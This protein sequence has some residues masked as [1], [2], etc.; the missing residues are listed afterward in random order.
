[1]EKGGGLG[2]RVVLP[3]MHDLAWSLPLPTVR[4][5][6]KE[7]SLSSAAAPAAVYAI[8]EQRHLLV[9]VVEHV[10]QMDTQQRTWGRGRARK[11]KKRRGGVGVGRRRGGV[12]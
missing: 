8:L 5:W 11:K 1:M 3:Q 10:N 2:R 12:E 7:A 6:L 4:A 9:Q